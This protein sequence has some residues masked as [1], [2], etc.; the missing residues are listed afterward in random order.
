MYYL[1]DGLGYKKIAALFAILAIFGSITVGNFAQVNSVILPLAKLGYNPFI[2]SLIIAALIGIVVL[3][4]I[5]RIAF[6]ASCIVPFMALLYL[7]TGLTVVGLH[8]DQLLPAFKML[9]AQ[10]FGFSS[11]AGGVLGFGVFKAIATGFD[12]GLFATDAGTGIVPI[13][14][15]SAKSD[16]PVMD[17]IST[18][19][20]PLMVMI[21]CTMTGLVLILTGAWLVPGLQSTNM[22]TYAF[23]HGL[24]SEIGNY[25]V[26][27]SLIL[28]A[29]TTA[30]AWAY[31]GEKAFEFLVGAEKRLW[32]RLA[33]VMLVPLGSLMQVTMI[34]SLADIAITCMLTA[35]LIGI[36]KLSDQVITSTRKYQQLQPN[37]S[38]AL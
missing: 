11:V 32:F 20:T 6:F 29:Y 9:F 33:F 7:V 37:R 18:L 36:M 34:W 27:I 23:S 21:V 2:C 16:Q 13:L 1:R 10:A 19:I 22:V 28:F 17:G 35:N 38:E 3:G 31:C 8:Y 15:A 12:R 14:Q 30:V 4:G 26:V 25:V 5:R 24:Q